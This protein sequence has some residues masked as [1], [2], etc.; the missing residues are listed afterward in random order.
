MAVAVP[1]TPE[2]MGMIGETKLR[3]MKPTAFLIN[4]ARGPV[5]DE[6]GLFRALRDQMIAAAAID[7]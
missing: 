7:V 2:T 1:Q 3:S 6:A 5:V 4:V